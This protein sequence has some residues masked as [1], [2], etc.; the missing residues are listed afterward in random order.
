[1]DAT[2]D[3]RVAAVDTGGRPPRVIVGVDGSPGSRAAL[4]YALIAAAGRG[5]ELEVVS[6]FSVQLVWTGV[7][8]LST[9]NVGAVRADTERRAGELLAEVRTDPAVTSVPG[10]AEVSGWVRVSAAS[11]AQAL[12]DAAADADLLVAPVAPQRPAHQEMTADSDAREEQEGTDPG[13]R[14]VADHVDP[15]YRPAHD[16]ALP[17]EPEDDGGPGGGSRATRALRRA[18]R[19][20]RVRSRA[21]APTGRASSPPTSSARPRAGRRLPGAGRRTAREPSR[22]RPFGP[23]WRR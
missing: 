5:A 22:T 21:W 14:G 1:M 8:P 10:A 9:P 15:T 23:R 17:V 6:T 13:Q 20:H 11:A 2:T 7:Y 16:A 4:V 3:N 19:R 18:R 12:V